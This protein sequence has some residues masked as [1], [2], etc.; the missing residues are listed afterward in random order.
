M[1]SRA[2]T[3]AFEGID[4][5]VVEVQC[6]L[7]PGIPNF[8]IVGL[9]NKSVSEARERVR[10]ALG[11]LSIGLPAK[12][13][14]INLSPADLPRRVPITTFPS[15]SPCSARSGQSTAANWTRSSLWASFL[16]TAA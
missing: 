13:I 1:V 14:T 2:Y 5:R 8:S 15:H 7:S 11:A 10:A 9:P 12:R 16:W 3:V 4:A 6:S